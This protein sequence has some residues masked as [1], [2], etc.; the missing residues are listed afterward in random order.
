[1]KLQV[2]NVSLE[3]PVILCLQFHVLVRLYALLFSFLD[4]SCLFVQ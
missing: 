2:D 1:M 4:S 3:D